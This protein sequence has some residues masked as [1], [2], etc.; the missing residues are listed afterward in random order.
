MDSF[1]LF[2]ASSVTNVITDVIM[3]IIPLFAI[4]N[5]HM[6]T[7]RKVGIAAIFAVGTAYVFFYL[8]SLHTPLS[9]R[10][11]LF[12]FFFFFFLDRLIFGMGMVVTWGPPNPN[13]QRQADDMG[14]S[15]SALGSSL[16]RLAW[17]LR[18]A[19]DPNRTIV[20]Q[21]VSLLA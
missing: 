7:Q 14:S 4:W 10:Y 16:A 9:S 19:K 21:K 18:H 1:A 3:L 11:P 6:A 17:Q 8:F 13:T 15:N 2:I 12:F 5:L 20:L